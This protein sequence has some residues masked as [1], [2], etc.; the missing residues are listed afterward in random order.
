MKTLTIAEFNIQV[1]GM[2]PE[3]AKRYVQ[4]LGKQVLQQLAEQTL[5]KEGLKTKHIDSLDTIN[6][7]LPKQGSFADQQTGSAA[8]IAAQVGQAVRA[9]NIVPLQLEKNSRSQ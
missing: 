1:K 5:S 8:M 3:E 6:I 2:K 9:Q 4:G 7:K